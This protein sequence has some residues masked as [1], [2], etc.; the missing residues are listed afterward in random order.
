MKRKTAVLFALLLALAL[1]LGGCGKEELRAG[2]D[3]F[4]LD[5]TL[6][7]KEPIYRLSCEYFLKGE[8]MGG[9]S[10]ENADGSAMCEETY[11]FRFDGDNF[12]DNSDLSGFSAVF[13]VTKSLGGAD[14][15]Q[16]AAHENQ[17]AAEGEIA[18][19]AQNGNIYP[20]RIAGGGDRFTASQ[21]APEAQ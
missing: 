2:E 9:L 13:Y 5:V 17:I 15:T 1:L 6:D 16:I 19:A 11:C 4:I 20:I 8:L 14:L 21:T 12:P 3:E 7:S 18:I 10:C